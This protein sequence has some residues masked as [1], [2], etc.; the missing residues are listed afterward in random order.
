M[1]TADQQRLVLEGGQIWRPD[2]VLAWLQVLSCTDL[3]TPLLADA[4]SC[5]AQDLKPDN[6]LLLNNDKLPHQCVAK[7][8]VPEGVGW[9][10]MRVERCGA[11]ST[12]LFMGAVPRLVCVWERGACLCKHSDQCGVWVYM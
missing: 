11:S 9:W 12:S 1:H 2:S 4:R 10:C 8:C 7:V 3:R 6:V 5:T